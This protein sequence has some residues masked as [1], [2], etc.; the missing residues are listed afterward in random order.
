MNE[1]MDDVTIT[2]GP[3]ETVVSMWRALGQRRSATP[4]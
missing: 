4:V 1:F 2:E 3:P